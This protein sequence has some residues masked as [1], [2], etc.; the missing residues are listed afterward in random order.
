MPTLPQIVGGRLAKFAMNW[1][2]LGPGSGL[3]GFIVYNSPHSPPEVGGSE[4]T[5]GPSGDLDVTLYCFLL[6]QWKQHWDVRCWEFH[7][8]YTSSVCLH[9]QLRK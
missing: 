2:V 1:T 6:L 8:P 5:P 7:I 3:R 4:A 9:M